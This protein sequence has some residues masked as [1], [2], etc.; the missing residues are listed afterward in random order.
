MNTLE[1]LKFIKKNFGTFGNEEGLKSKYFEDNIKGIVIC[2]M[3]SKKV[4]NFAIK[5]NFNLIISHE[6]LDFPPE[7]AFGYVKNKGFVSNWRRKNLEDNRINFVSL[8]ATIDRN[9]IFDVFDEMCNGE[10][11]LKEGYF[12]VYEF[13]N[14]SLKVLSDELKKKFKV[15]FLRVI[16]KNKRVRRAGCLV[17]GLGLSINAFKICKLY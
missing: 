13:K 6:D 12:R 11:V 1:F 10:V 16:E 5:N 8:H 14:K 4:L 3:V 17:G 15:K 9:F 2:W 7:Y